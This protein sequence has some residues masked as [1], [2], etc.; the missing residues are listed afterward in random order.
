M[1]ADL[2]V[3]ADE[4]IRDLDIAVQ[5]STD[6]PSK[7]PSMRVALHRFK[8]LVKLKLTLPLAQ[9][10]AAREDMERFLQHRLDELHSHS[11]TRN[12]VESLSERVAA[13]QSRVHQILYGEPLK[14]IEVILR[15]IMGMAADQPVEGNF[16]PGILEGL[17]GRFS[18]APFRETN[19]S[20]SSREGAARQWA[21][22]VLGAVQKTENRQVKLGTSGMPPGLHLNYEDFLNCQSHHIPGIFT[23]PLSLFTMV[24]SMYKL[25]KPPVLTEAP[26]FSAADNCPTTPVGKDGT[27]VPTT[28]N[29]DAELDKTNMEDSSHLAQAL[30]YKSDHTL[31]KWTRDKPESKGSHD[32]APSPKRAMVKKEVGDDE[33]PSSSGL[34]VETLHDHRFM[35]YSKDS[36]AVHEV[37]AK[38]LGLTAG[39]KPS[40]QDIDSSLIF[41]LRRAAD[42]SGSPSIIGEHWVPHLR[43]RGHLADC[44]PKD[45]SFKD[46]W[47]PLYMRVGITKHLSGLESL[48]NRDKT[49]PLIAVVLPKV[50][51]QYEQEYVIH[52]L[53][54]SE[55]L[56]RTSI[57]Y[58]TNQ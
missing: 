55:S 48:L 31:R 18:I 54:K 25:T 20:T 57:T 42:E 3:T 34:S 6:P 38:I 49:S 40:R 17:L 41:A 47:L 15:V 36:P 29:S 28:G 1:H 52:K 33:S 27:P 44:K 22:A 8:E 53:H 45:F 37:R 39:M 12:L 50:E 46:K 43:Q 19:P 58:N 16:F 26:P 21:A 5:N 2:E 51:F 13:H 7:N 30:P 56:N 11:S 23:D 35:V 10:D 32:G 4:L 24:H 9:V 14:H